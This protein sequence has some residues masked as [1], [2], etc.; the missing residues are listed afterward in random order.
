MM[1]A[2]C[3][4]INPSKL[5]KNPR[6]NF[7]F[8]Q[9]ARS[10]EW[11]QPKITSYIQVKYESTHFIW[12]WLY[13]Q[14][15]HLNCNWHNTARVKECYPPFF[16]PRSEGVNEGTSPACLNSCNSLKFIHDLT[17]T[18]ASYSFFLPASTTSRVRWC[19]V[20]A[21]TCSFAFTT[22]TNSRSEFCKGMGR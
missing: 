22:L 7:R 6:H 18:L 19:S 20:P 9:P 13:I 8:Y 14:S 5:E 16:A 10:H 15:Y 12:Q 3:K 4:N 1:D 17:Q 21:T 2:S 11:L